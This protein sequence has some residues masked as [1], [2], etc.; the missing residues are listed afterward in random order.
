MNMQGNNN[1]GIL[2]KDIKNSSINNILASDEKENIAIN[3]IEKKLAKILK[4][5]NKGLITEKDYN[6][7]KAELLSRI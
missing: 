7:K 3:N 1:I 5:K 6:E 2:S 4:M